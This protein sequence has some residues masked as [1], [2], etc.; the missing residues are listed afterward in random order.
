MNMRKSKNK[1]KVTKPPQRCNTHRIDTLA[2]RM[3]ESTLPADWIKRSVE[4]RD[5]GI[6]M[7]LEAF[8]G[9][10]PT[11]VL[12]LLQVKGREASF[13]REDVSMSVPVKTLLY[14]Q[15]FQTPFFLVHASLG[16][17]KAYFVWLQKYIN[18]R[19]ASDSPQ[20][21]RQDHV[22]IRFPSDNLLDRD[23]LS[24]IRDLVT[25]VVHRDMGVTFLSHLIWLRQHVENYHQGGGKHELE[26]AL[27]R[28]NE[29]R[30]LEEF[31]ASYEDSCEELDLDELWKALDKATAYGYFDYEDDE[32]VD[33]QL[34]HLHAVEMMFL[35]KDDGDAF[36]SE[37]LETNMPY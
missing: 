27:V 28:V 35:S 29:I 23:G 18:T 14:A 24:K 33:A 26:E 10:D 22:T 3:V 17:Q 5:Y 9:D 2:V 11:G 19:L 8:D 21:N 36:V 32:L 7:M 4:D 6:D 12:V 20:W 31:L 30:K 1:Q 13:G 25:Y 15:M 34:A 37:N 16:D